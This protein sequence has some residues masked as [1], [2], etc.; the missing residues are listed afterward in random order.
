M[1]KLKCQTKL[2]V[3]ISKFCIKWLERLVTPA[4]AGIQVL[5]PYFWIPVFLPTGRQARE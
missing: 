3:Q 5:Y 4:E 1:L 2:K